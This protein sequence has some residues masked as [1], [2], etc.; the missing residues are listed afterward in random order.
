MN[1][2]TLDGAMAMT[3]EYSPSSRFDRVQRGVKYKY[4]YKYKYLAMTME[5]SPSSRWNIHRE[6]CETSCLLFFVRVYGY[7]SIE[8]RPGETSI[9]FHS[10]S[11]SR[12]HGYPSIE[13][14]PGGGDESVTV[15][16]VEEFVERTVDWALYRS[17]FEIFCFKCDKS[18]TSFEKANLSYTGV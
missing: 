13:L 15:H 4:K 7:P 14:R 10:C 12:V 16:N 3:M 17:Y 18:G 8:L 1:N 2:L 5:Y 6:N 11:F 9:K